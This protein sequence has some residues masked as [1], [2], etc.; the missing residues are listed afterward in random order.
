[1]FYFEREGEGLWAEQVL[2]KE[3]EDLLVGLSSS[4]DGESETGGRLLRVN[5]IKMERVF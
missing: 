2:E 1:M 5:E 4:V 3:V